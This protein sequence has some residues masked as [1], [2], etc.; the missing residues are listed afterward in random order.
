MKIKKNKPQEECD[1]KINA[2]KI[3]KIEKKSSILHY[4]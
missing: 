1:Y 2:L 3:F 4:K